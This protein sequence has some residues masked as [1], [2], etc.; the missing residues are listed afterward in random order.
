MS[1]SSQAYNILY[2]NILLFT[3]HTT[4][5]QRLN[6][7]IQ[8]YERISDTMANPF[9]RCTL[10]LL[11]RFVG[12]PRLHIIAVLALHFKVKLYCNYIQL[13]RLHTE[14]LTRKSAMS[15]HTSCKHTRSHK[16]RKCKCVYNIQLQNMCFCV[17]LRGVRRQPSDDVISN[18]IVGDA[19]YSCASPRHVAFVD[20]V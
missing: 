7:L 4:S 19:P 13:Y 8:L 20:N 2:Y 15:T 5:D 1:F 9:V 16:L 12:S 18:A 11:T 14:C 10:N 17:D 3:L 6:I